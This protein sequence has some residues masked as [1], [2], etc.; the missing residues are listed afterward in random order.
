VSGEI[1]WARRFDHMQQHTGQHVLSAVFE[2]LFGF[3]TLSVHFGAESSSIDLATKS[4]TRDE[5]LRAES[6][7]NEIAMENRPVA[8]SFEDAVTAAG[9][10][11]PPPRDGEIRIV[12]VESIDRSACGGTHVRSTAE[13]GPVHLRKL[14]RMHGNARVEF[15]CGARALRQSRS[16]FELLGAAAA[17]LGVT[18]EEV[19][20]RSTVLTENLRDA[21]RVRRKLEVEVAAF[22]AAAAYSRAQPNALGA[23]FIVERSEAG[24]LDDLR[25]MAHA[26]TGFPRVAYLGVVLNSA[27]LLLSTSEDSGLDAGKLLKAALTAVGGRGGGSARVAQ[28]TTTVDALESVIAALAAQLN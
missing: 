14:D 12:T 20:S 13:I 26:L 6:R 5:I 22:R 9:L 8:V 18:P 25:A 23:R 27:Q 7:A 16:D 10:R 24:K 28:G 1:N 4:L 11:K 21:E 19:P 15:L 3:S 2:D 17:A